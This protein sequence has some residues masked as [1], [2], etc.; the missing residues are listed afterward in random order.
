[1]NLIEFLKDKLTTSIVDK[2]GSFLGEAPES[3]TSALDAALPTIL[4]GLIQQGSTDAG[5]K[6]IMAIIKDG[7]HSGEIMSELP[8]LFDN[9]DKTQLLVTIGSNIFN[10]F[11]GNTA[12]TLTDKIAN[13]SGIRKT[14]SASLL[15]LTAPLALGA[16]G[17]VVNKENLGISGLKNLFDEQREEIGKLLPDTIATHLPLRAITTTQEQEIREEP[18][19]Q[20]KQQAKAPEIKNTK[21]EESFFSK[22]LPWIILVLLGLLTAYYLRSCQT[23]KMG[24]DTAVVAADTVTTT[25]DESGIIN[26]SS[27][28]EDNVSA[29]DPTSN[30]EESKADKLDTPASNNNS[31][32]STSSTGGQ[33]RSGSEITLSSNSFKS[34]SAEIRNSQT[35]NNLARYLKRNRRA[36]LSIYP[37]GNGRLAE[38][39]AYAIREQLYQKGIDVSRISIESA[40]GNGDGV[41][42]KI[43][44]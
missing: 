17:Y 42:V 5:A 6:K 1:M 4:G 34:G 19:Q 10:H 12:G 43:N 14:S 16:I 11:F 28:V 31:T 36:S 13:L 35:I 18:K 23:K 3:V 8:A 41:S 37:A 22:A 25:T 9:F 24:S 26:D 29:G 40:R 2:M 20:I 30:R 21:K 27:V 33:L 32:R 7:G 15:G 38:D 39:R 44:R